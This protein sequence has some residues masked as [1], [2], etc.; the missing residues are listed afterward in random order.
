MYS[1]EELQGI[2][3]IFVG[4]MSFLSPN[5]QRQSTE[6]Q[7]MKNMHKSARNYRP[8]AGD[9]GVLETWSASYD[10]ELDSSGRDVSTLSLMACLS[11]RCNTSA[12]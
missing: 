2:V 6:W 8:Y 4:Q 10:D 11:H 5:Q 1:K 7:H 12:C 9:V 3:R